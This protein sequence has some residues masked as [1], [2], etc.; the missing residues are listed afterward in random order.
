MKEHYQS[1]AGTDFAGGLTHGLLGL[2]GAGQAYDPLGDLRGALANAN[3][4]LQ[5]AQTLGAFRCG[6]QQ[7]V[8][9]KALMKYTQ[10]NTNILNEQ[11][12][13]FNDLANDKLEEVNVFLIMLTLLVIIIIFFL[14]I[15]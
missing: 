13:F 15:K 8:W 12:K 5:N 7:D 9:D 2:I 3:T 14:L 1:S 11:Q 10:G 6:V 4:E